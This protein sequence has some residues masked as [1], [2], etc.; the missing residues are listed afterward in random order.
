MSAEPEEILDRY[1]R[2]GALPSPRY[3]LV[4]PSVYMAEQEKERAI[5]HFLSTKLSRSLSTLR[6]LEVG[7]GNG[8][9]L[10][11][12]IRAGVAP[13]NLCG[14]DIIGDRI[15]LARTLLPEAVDL[16]S[17]NA[18]DIVYDEASF[19]IVYQSTVFSS[20][21]DARFRQKLA[22]YMWR[23]V[24]PGGFILWYDFIYNNPRNP[25]VLG[26]PLNEFRS[27]FPYGPCEG[28]SL[29]LA[30][31]LS[32]ALTKIHPALY[33][34]CNCLPFLRTHKLIWLQKELS[35]YA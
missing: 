4:E 7:C 26:M 13:G 33:T 8:A 23:Y 34:I 28:Q 16:R 35:S 21:L 11:Q 25:D 32:R 12:F 18:L 14:N 2:R 17:G 30:P 10:L 29:T 3:Q 22:A 6:I 9:N 27:L 20:I 31:P 5:L 19:D 24:T 15:A 1:R